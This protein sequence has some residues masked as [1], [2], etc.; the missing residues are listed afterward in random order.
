MRKKALNTIVL[1]VLLVTEMNR[2]VVNN[3]Y[4]MRYFLLLI[5]ALI[6]LPLQVSGDEEGPMLIGN[7][8][9][10]SSENIYVRLQNSPDLNLG[11][12]LYIESDNQWIAALIIDQRSSISCVGTAISDKELKLL[13][14]MYN[15]RGIPDKN[16]IVADQDSIANGEKKIFK[17]QKIDGRIRASSYSN[18]SNS[19]VENRHKL[20]YTL[21]LSAKNL[22]GSRLSAESY[23]SF[24]HK[25]GE[26]SEVNENVF[27][28]L[29]IYSLALKYEA[30][31]NTNLW[32][33]RKINPRLSHIGAVDGLMGETKIKNISVGGVAGTRPDYSDYGI[34][35]K[36]FE[37]GAYVGHSH[38]SKNGLIQSSLAM[39]EQRNS[40]N[41]DRRFA[42]FQHSSSLLKNLYLFTSSELEL[43][44][45]EEG[46]SS[47][48][49]SLTSL[50]FS[51]RYRVFKKLTLFASYDTRKNVI[52]YETFKDYA[53]RLL[54]EATRQGFRFN[55]NYRPAKKISIGVNS[56]YRYRESDIRPTKNVNGFINISQ[57]PW[58]KMSA[59]FSANY[60]QTSYLDGYLLR[61]R[62]SRDVIPGVLNMGLNYRYTDYKF[63]NN[64]TTLLQNTV[65]ANLR[66]TIAKKLSCSID[67]EST[68]EGSN[69]YQRVYLNF[70]KRL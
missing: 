36:L 39:F 61:I 3:C 70:I 7:I 27:N 60:L 14:P 64:N 2:N 28:A 62:L 40:G 32:I 21:S 33:G 58:V 13:D 20:R 30:G 42:Y 11:D 29:K 63:N 43:Y 10:I 48:S 16:I 57:V 49:P 6:L 56:G 52:Y 66:W 1:L 18:F 17:E 44:K 59:T 54:E 23:T 53:D 45:V 22:G 9:Y 37:Y 12:T 55:I 69:R 35:L 15:G 68:F 24:S 46:V 8:S 19:D 25:L 50:Y 34:N 5:L 47:T 51:L 41:I 31:E 38:K 26:W 65:Q 67:I 4:F